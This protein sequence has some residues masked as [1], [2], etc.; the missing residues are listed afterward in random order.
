MELGVSTVTASSGRNWAVSMKKVTNRKAR[1][2]IGVMSNAG[3]LRG[4]LSFGM[5]F[6]WGG[7]RLNG[8]VLVNPVRA[9]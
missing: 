5:I 6:G 3:L 1:S 8:H 9:T 7:C 4:I 2:T